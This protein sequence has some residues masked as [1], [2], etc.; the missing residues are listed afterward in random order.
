MARVY[1][2]RGLLGLCAAALLTGCGWFGGGNA[3]PHHAKARPG[4][5]QLIPATT[6]LPPA[7]P[8]QQHDGGVAPV[9][10]TRG[11]VGSSVTGKGGQKAQ[12]EA[13]QKEAE[14]RSRQERERAARTEEER[15][16]EPPAAPAAPAPPA[17]PPPS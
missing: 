3:Y 1:C 6:A 12:Q 8:G 5:D 4:A 15:K 2:S 11:P 10:E 14:E 16:A 7:S 17:A 13:T 9:D